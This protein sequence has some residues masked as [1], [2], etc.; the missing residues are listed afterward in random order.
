[1]NTPSWVEIPRYMHMFWSYLNIHKPT[2]LARK[3]H[4]INLFFRSYS[5]IINLSINRLR[6]HRT[7][8]NTSRVENT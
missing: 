3:Y 2:R 4:T 6:G 5:H 1:M 7:G 8:S